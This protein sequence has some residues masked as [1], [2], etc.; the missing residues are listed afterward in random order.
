VAARYL[1]TA[2]LV[3]SATMNERHEPARGSVGRELSCSALL[4]ERV[5][6]ADEAHPHRARHE[7]EALISRGSAHG[8]VATGARFTRRQTRLGLRVRRFQ[9]WAVRRP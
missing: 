6:V 3:G 7:D 5:E 4:A 9:A 2:E 8:P 1:E